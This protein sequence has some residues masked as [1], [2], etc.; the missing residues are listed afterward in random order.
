MCSESASPC[1]SCHANAPE[2]YKVGLR[3]EGACS[4]ASKMVLS[5]E[6]ACSL[7]CKMVLSREGACFVIKESSSSRRCNV[8]RFLFYHL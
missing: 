2:T 5:R 1:L 4:L 3:S 8:R 7:A 6:G